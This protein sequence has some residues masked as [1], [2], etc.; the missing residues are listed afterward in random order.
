MS[1]MFH[2][3]VI[4]LCVLLTSL[5]FVPLYFCHALSVSLHKI[6]EVREG[7]NTEK[8]DKFPFE[9]VEHQ[10]FSLIFEE[11]CKSIYMCLSVCVTRDSI[12]IHA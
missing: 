5:T 6:V 9:Q 8:F 12:C 10:S 1:Y 7:Q 2:D 4:I 3:D 11:E